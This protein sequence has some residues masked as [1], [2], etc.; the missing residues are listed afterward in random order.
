MED[1]LLDSLHN[2]IGEADGRTTWSKG[3]ALQFDD[4]VEWMGEE[5]A[6]KRYFSKYKMQRRFNLSY[7]LSTA[8]R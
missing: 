5:E 7:P 8:L 6:A 3:C 4:T 2:P 1:V